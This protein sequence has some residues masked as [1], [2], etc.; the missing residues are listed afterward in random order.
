[1]PEI[2]LKPKIIEATA[3][4]RRPLSK[5]LAWGFVV[6]CVVALGWLFWTRDEGSTASLFG[7]TVVFSLAL[8]LILAG[9]FHDVD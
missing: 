2:D 8:G 7:A 5:P 6:A 1:M 9:I 3:R 4:R